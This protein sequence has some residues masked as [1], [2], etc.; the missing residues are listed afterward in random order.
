[1]SSR[2]CMGEALSRGAAFQG[3][4]RKKAQ[5]A[6]RYQFEGGTRGF[7]GLLAYAT[8]KL[9]EVGKHSRNFHYKAGEANLTQTWP[10]GPCTHL[11]EVS[12]T[13]FSQEMSC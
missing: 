11:S 7:S 1:M 3:L 6:R 13:E 4:M 5:L 10:S 2:G 12:G 8:R 9:G